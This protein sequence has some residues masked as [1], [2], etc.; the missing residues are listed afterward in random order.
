MQVLF[1]SEEARQEEKLSPKACS[2]KVRLE[3]YN[4][5]WLDWPRKEMD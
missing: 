2:S 3:N 1:M 5:G 4:Q